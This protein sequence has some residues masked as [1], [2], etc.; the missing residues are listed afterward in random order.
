[1]DRPQYTQELKGIPYGNKYIIKGANHME[2]LD[3]S[4]STLN[5]QPN[6][7]TYD[8]FS[9]IFDRQPGDWF[10]TSK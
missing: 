1:M 8:T 4:K 7:G 2:V 9:I 3:M 10:R 5:G 6:D